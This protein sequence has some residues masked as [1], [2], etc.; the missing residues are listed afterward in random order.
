MLSENQELRE[1]AQ[2]QEAEGGVF[3]RDHAE[4]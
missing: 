3:K 1:R 4:E 2:L